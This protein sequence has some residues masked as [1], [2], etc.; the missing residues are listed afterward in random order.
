MTKGASSRSQI[1]CRAQIKRELERLLFPNAA[2]VDVA[3]ILPKSDGSVP[4]VARG[5]G[6]Y[7]PSYVQPNCNGIIGSLFLV[8]SRPC[9]HLVVEFPALLPAYGAPRVTASR[10]K[11]LASRCMHVVRLAGLLDAR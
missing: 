3:K 6:V 4:L 7:I 2:R 1:V 5:R 8:P 11:F 9:N 10:N